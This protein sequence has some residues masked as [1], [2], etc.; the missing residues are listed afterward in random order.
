MLVL[1]SNLDLLTMSENN[2]EL[3][4]IIVD[5]GSSTFRAGW[6]GDD[7]PEIITPSI[8]VDIS[9]MLY[10][11][12]IISGLEDIFIKED[13]EKHLFGQEALNYINILKVHEF[14][15]ENNYFILSKFFYYYYLK[16]NITSEN[17][18]KQPI[19]ILAPLYLTELDKAKLQQIF[20][21]IFKFP[22]LLFVPESQ[23]ILA[24]LQKTSGVVIDIGEAHT[25]ISSIFHGFTNELARDAFPI[26]GKDLTN[27]FLNLILT[28][29]GSGKNIYIDKILAKEIKE[30]T[31]LCVID[32]KGEKKRIDEGLTKYNQTINFPDGTNLEINSERF[33]TVEP[34][35]DPKII[36]IDYIGIN[37]AIAKVIK[38][39]AREN[40]EEILPTIVLSGGGSLIPGLKERLKIEIEKHFPEKLGQKINIIAVSGRENM[41]WIGASILYSKNQLK[42]WI[43]NPELE[44]SESQPNPQEQ[45]DVKSNIEN[46]QS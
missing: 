9:D 3:R 32:P 44:T 22:L 6:A 38:T 2:K 24:T 13:V 43:N 34:L 45:Q 28:T 35:F 16:L 10:Q 39:W 17:Q 12:D 31:C 23:A 7:F 36:H 5:L 41:S 25:S 1:N 4:P 46:N 42:G 26:S 18:F 27:N 20:F 37:E 33:L 29:K 14:I 8:Y 11:S 30:K 21:G 40:W 19:I 15:Q